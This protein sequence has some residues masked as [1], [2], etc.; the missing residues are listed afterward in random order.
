MLRSHILID[1][2]LTDC[3]KNQNGNNIITLLKNKAAFPTYTIELVKKWL[4]YNYYKILLN[5]IIKYLIIIFY[6]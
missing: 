6:N 3:S 4:H 1:E 5:L 2:N